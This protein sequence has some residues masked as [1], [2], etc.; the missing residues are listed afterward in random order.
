MLNT[1][2]VMEAF[3]SGLSNRT[4]LAVWTMQF[5]YC[6]DSFWFEEGLIV[7]RDIVHE[8]LGSNIL[9]QFLMIPF[10]FIVQARY[11]QLASYETS[12]PYNCAVILLFGM[13]L[14]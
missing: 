2:F 12:F 9:L 8:G 14:A 6:F 4:L 11:L 5:I 13:S 3:Q 10:T 7:S 1:V